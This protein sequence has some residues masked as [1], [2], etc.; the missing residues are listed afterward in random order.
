MRHEMMMMEMEMIWWRIKRQREKWDD[1]T[2]ACFLWK[3]TQEKV[4]RTWEHSRL[5]YDMNGRLL[6]SFEQFS[7]DEKRKC[8]AILFT[9]ERI[10]LEF[11]I[12]LVHVGTT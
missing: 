1:E 11:S 3:D 9:T 8:Y 6:S 4:S 2:I 7:G 10:N 12:S 5:F